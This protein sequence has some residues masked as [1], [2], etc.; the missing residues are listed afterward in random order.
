MTQVV[1]VSFGADR[2]YEFAVAA[3][4]MAGMGKEDARTW[5]ADEF[6]ALECTPSNPMGKVLVLDMILNV[7]KYGGEARFRDPG[8]WARRFAVAAAVA[9]PRPVIRIDVPN[10]IVG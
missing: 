4:D 8:E 2:E 1:I 10:F 6:D 3:A 9:L 5:L 7:A